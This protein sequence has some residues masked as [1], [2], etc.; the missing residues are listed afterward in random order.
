MPQ[1]LK[2]FLEQSNVFLT[3]FFLLEMILKLVG[4]GMY[5]YSQDAF[6][7]FDGPSARTKQTQTTT[8]HQETRLG[9]CGAH[10]FHDA[11]LSKCRSPHRAYTRT[12]ERPGGAGALPVVAKGGGGNVYRSLHIKIKS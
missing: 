8:P 5:V 2:D 7:R 6:N 10:F 4:M 12:R 3:I 11:T 1:S 9:L